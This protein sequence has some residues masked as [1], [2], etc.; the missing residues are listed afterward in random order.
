MS[1]IH[2]ASLAA[3]IF[4][5]A[6]VANFISG[7]VWQEPVGIALF[8]FYALLILN[9]FFS[10]RF[11]SS[12]VPSDDTQKIVDSILFLVYIALAFS[13]DNEIVFLIIVTSL[14]LVASLKY[15]L[16]LKHTAYRKVL[17]RKIRLNLIGATACGAAIVG[18]LLGH[19]LESAWVLSVVFG[20][21][22][23]Y[24]LFIRPM[25]RLP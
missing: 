7:H 24:L 6:G 11:F 4:A 13:M 16:L 20:L 3:V 1:P 25:Y 2:R 18:S 15:V 21:A 22:N 5:I 10:I 17:S 19:T 23:V 14:F 8:A 12:L 9:T